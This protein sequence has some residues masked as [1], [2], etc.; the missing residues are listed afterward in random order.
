M[1]LSN[2]FREP[3]RE[4]TETLVGIAALLVPLFLDY[5]FA[6]WLQASEGMDKNGEYK[7]PWPAGMF[8]GFF[9]FFLAL[10][11]LGLAHWMGEKTCDA[12]ARRGLNLRPPR[13]Y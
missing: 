13:R 4:I 7:W 9:L 11:V 10:V 5:C 12:L 8:L 1:A 2:I 6:L 3:R